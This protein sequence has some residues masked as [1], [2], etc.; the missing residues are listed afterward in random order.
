MLSCRALF[1]NWFDNSQI[2]RAEKKIGPKLVWVL[3]Y[4]MLFGLSK[5]TRA[6]LMTD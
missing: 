3:K 6:H 2:L 4:Q 5:N 1:D